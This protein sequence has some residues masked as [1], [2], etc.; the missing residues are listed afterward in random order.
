AEGRIGD[1]GAGLGRAAGRLGDARPR[2]SG[3]RL[4]AALAEWQGELERIAELL[5]G[6]EDASAGLARCR[7]RCL[8]G[9]ARLERIF[10]PD[11]AGLRWLE[12]TQR[13]LAAHW[14]PLDIGDALAAR[15]EVQGGAWIF[16]SATLA[17]GDDFSHFRRRIGLA[18]T[19]AD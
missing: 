7:E 3:D 17:V 12:R 10:A 9:A 6:V 8:A 2:S 16:A 13:S 18:D 4:G 15:I 1:D 14:T 5:T 11:G 19:E